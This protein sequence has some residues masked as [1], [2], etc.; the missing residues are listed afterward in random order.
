MKPLFSTLIVLLLS[1]CASGIQPPT[2][3]SA[4]IHGIHADLVQAGVVS[5]S[6][7]QNWNSEQTESFDA[8]VRAL[9]CTQTTS[10]PVVAIISGPVTMALSGSFTQSGSFSVSTSGAI[11]VFGLNADASRIHAQQLTLPVQF[12]PLSALPDTELAREV[13]YAGELLAQNDDVRHATAARL[14]TERDALDLHISQQVHG[15]HVTQCRVPQHAFPFVSTK[16]L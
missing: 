9:Q 14:M 3:I 2:T 15:F 10:D 16:R 12:I 11:P 8:N 1:G 5:T 7:F 4:A 6:H 13:E